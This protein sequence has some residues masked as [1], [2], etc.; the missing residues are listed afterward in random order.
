MKA[1]PTQCM[2]DPIPCVICGTP[3][4]PRAYNSTACSATCRQKRNDAYNAQLL[5]S[6]YFTKYQRDNKDVIQ[7]Q[8]Q[9]EVCRQDRQK[10]R[11]A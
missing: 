1:Y 5:E 10:K 4:K 7:C 6:G 11:N 9:P 2:Y 8:A 3:F